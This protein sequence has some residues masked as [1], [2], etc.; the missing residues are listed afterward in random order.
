M[1]RSLRNNVGVHL[2][3]WPITRC[4]VNVCPKPSRGVDEGDAPKRKHV[5]ERDFAVDAGVVR[6]NCA[7]EHLLTQRYHQ[8]EYVHD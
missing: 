1:T 4:P 6:P 8:I 3:R 5:T 2:I 7:S